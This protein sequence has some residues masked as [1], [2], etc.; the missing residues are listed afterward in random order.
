[1]STSSTTHARSMLGRLAERAATIATGPQQPV[2]HLA[3]VAH[4]RWMLDQ[5]QQQLVDGARAE[6]ATW[7]Q[8]A[9]ALGVSRQAARQRYGIS[10]PEPDRDQLQ[11]W[12]YAPTTPTA[13]VPA[14]RRAQPS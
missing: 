7:G 12:P 6:G 9:R 2:E 8:I 14:A 4:L 13:V 5:A 11:L 3:T 10:H 1:M